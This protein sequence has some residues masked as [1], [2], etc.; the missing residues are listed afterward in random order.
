MEE[1]NN[2][3]GRTRCPSM[4]VKHDEVCDIVGTASLD[5]IFYHVVASVN[6]VR[7]GEDQAHLLHSRT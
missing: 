2:G 3:E 7:I 4:F 6:P 5:K 1:S